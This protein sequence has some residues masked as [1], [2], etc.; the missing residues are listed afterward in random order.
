MEHSLSQLD[1]LKRDLQ[2]LVRSK[3]YIQQALAREAR[4]SQSAISN[5]LRGR[6]G[7]SCYA[8]LSLWPFIYGRPFPE[9]IADNHP[10]AP[11]SEDV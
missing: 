1:S 9:K 8:F 10:S 6:R 2:E 11:A 7:L 3:K 5:F 4:I